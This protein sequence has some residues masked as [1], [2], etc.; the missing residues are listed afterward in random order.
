LH[1]GDKGGTYIEHM[2]GAYFGLAVSYML[3]KPKHEPAGGNVPDLFSLIGTLFLWVYW[4]S[5][6]AGDAEPGSPQQQSAIVHTILALSSSTVTTFFLSSVL[7]KSGKFRPVDVQ[8]ATLAGGVSIGC[9]A[10]LSIHPA[11]AILIGIVAAAVST[12]GF[13]TIQPALEAAGL[14]DTCSVHNLHA[15]P[16]IVGAVASIIA[17]AALKSEDA[18]IFGEFAEGQWRRQLVGMLATASFA[19]VT[20][21][22]T[23]KVCQLFKGADSASESAAEDFQD[24]LWWEVAADYAGGATSHT[25]DAAATSN[26]P[27]D[28]EMAPHK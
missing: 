8:N 13:N 25:H 3:G 20:G 27:R 10:N 24:N 21:L 18:K 9:V 4:P 6:V 22:I 19:I 5:F 7:G 17:S 2:I 14:H 28:V 26:E 16:S 23:G 11:G 15:M 12:Y 1:V